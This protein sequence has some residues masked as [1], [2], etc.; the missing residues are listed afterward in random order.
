MISPQVLTQLLRYPAVFTILKERVLL[1]PKLG[2]ETERSNAL[3]E[4]LLD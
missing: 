4:V 2:T 1:N 3:E